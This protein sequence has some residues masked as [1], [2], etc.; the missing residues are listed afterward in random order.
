MIDHAA[1]NIGV[2]LLLKLDEHR[3]SSDEFEGN[4]PKKTDDNAVKSIGYWV[5]T[6]FDDEHDCI[7]EIKENSE[8][9]LILRNSIEFLNSDQILHLKMLGRYE[10]IKTILSEGTEW[11]GCELPWHKKWP[12][13]E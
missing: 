12:F 13:P 11:L 3:L 8:E 4:W 10:K 5:W 6:L 9:K 1:R 2:E 7:I